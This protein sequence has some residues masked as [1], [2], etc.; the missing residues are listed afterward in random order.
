MFESQRRNGRDPHTGRPEIFKSTAPA[1]IPSPIDPVPSPVP[2]RAPSLQILIAVAS[3]A[4]LRCNGCNGCNGR[5]EM[6]QAS[7]WRPGLRPR[8]HRVRS[9]RRERARSA[10][11]AFPVACHIATLPH[12]K[13]CGNVATIKNCKIGA[14]WG[15]GLGTGS[16][17]DGMSAGAVDLI[18]GMRILP[19]WSLTLRQGYI[20]K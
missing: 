20:L 6:R 12:L 4:S 9:G 3:V 14:L 11:V 7:L 13:R 16:I 18:F 8:A 15:T 2:H 5:P 1:L 10:V 17:G 19:I